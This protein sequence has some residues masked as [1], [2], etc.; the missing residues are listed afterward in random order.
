MKTTAPN[1]PDLC[2][3]MADD[4][5]EFIRQ[6]KFI[7]MA[8]S[9]VMEVSNFNAGNPVKLAEPEI[10]FLYDTDLEGNPIESN[11]LTIL[12]DEESN[13]FSIALCTDGNPKFP[14]FSKLS[15]LTGLNHR[16]PA[17]S[18]NSEKNKSPKK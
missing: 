9:N 15:R 12:K 17:V 13:R 5:N 8:F 11:R 4:L 6:C 10:K 18:R 7:V 2:G 3:F 14:C 1:M 16:E